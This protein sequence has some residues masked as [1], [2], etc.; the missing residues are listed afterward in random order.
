M[1]DLLLL[2]I[3]LASLLLVV[4]F[5]LHGR[6]RSSRNLPLPPGPKGLPIIGNML[7]MDQLTHHGLAKLAKQYGGLFHLRMGNINMVTVSSPEIAKQVLK[8]QY[9]PFWRQ[10]RKI[11]VMKLFSRRRAESW[12]SVRDEIDSMV[13][14]VAANPTGNPINVGELIFTFTMNLTYRAAFGTSNNNKGQME[15]FIKILQEF[16]RLFGA[17]NIADFIPFLGWMDPQGLFPRMV[18]AR[19]SLDKFIDQIMDDHLLK[20][21]NTSTQEDLVP[22]P[23]MVDELLAFYQND[24]VDQPL[25]KHNI[26]AIIMDVMFGGTETVASVIEWAMAELLKSLD[27]LK[28]V[29]QELSNVVG[30]NR[31]VEER[32]LDKLTFLKCILKETLRLHPPIPL[33]LHE[34]AEDTEWVSGYFIPKRS[35]V[36]VNAYAIARDPNSWVNPNEF[37]PARFMKEGMPDFKGSNFEFLPFGSGRRSCPGMQLGLYAIELGIAHLLHSFDWE[38]PNGMKPNQVDMSDAFGLTAPRA[39]RLIAVPNYGL[40]C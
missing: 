2:L 20:K 27:D 40:T 39:T 13:Q 25:T 30:L 1:A 34:T 22:N 33:L 23:D 5:L 10:M 32:D 28:C 11:S 19:S 7:I 3:I 15:E 29:Q 12:E 18:N 26:K 16:S 35:R 36:M 6:S 4:V 8:S 17:F 38:L 31:H 21:K 14:T 37:Y 24:N 9:G